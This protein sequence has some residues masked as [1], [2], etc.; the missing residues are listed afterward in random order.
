QPKASALSQAWLDEFSRKKLLTV[1]LTRLA[2]VAVV[3]GLLAGLSCQLTSSTTV[4][5][6]PKVYLRPELGVPVTPPDPSS[7]SSSRSLSPEATAIAPSPA[8]DWAVSTPSS[9]R[10][11][12][13]TS[14]PD[15]SVGAAAAKCSEKR[16]PKSVFRRLCKRCAAGV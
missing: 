8:P 2:I 9:S 10:P 3:H 16:S 15:T 14:A 7:A 13:R 12:T 1:P 6:S 5:C 4:F 11:S